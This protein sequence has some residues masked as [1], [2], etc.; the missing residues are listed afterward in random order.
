LGGWFVTINFFYFLSLSYLLWMKFH[1]CDIF[2][3]FPLLINEKP[4]FAWSF[5]K[6]TI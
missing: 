4:A 6:K 1:P 2:T 5:K 3:V